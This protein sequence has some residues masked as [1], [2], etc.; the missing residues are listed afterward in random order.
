MTVSGLGSRQPVQPGQPVRPTNKS[1]KPPAPDSEATREELT[2]QL[3]GAPVKSIPAGKPF[4]DDDSQLTLVQNPVPQLPVKQPVDL[5]DT[6]HE[7]VIQKAT[8]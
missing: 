2:A 7:I 6:L 5:E 4:D 3:F 8:D 1:T